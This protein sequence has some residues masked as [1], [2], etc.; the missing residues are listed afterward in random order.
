MKAS[1]WWQIGGIAL[2]SFFLAL[3]ILRAGPIG[4]QSEVAVGYAARTA[5]ACRY[6]GLRSLAS[7]YT[8]FEPGMGSVRLTEDPAEQRITAAVP[9]IA[10]RSAK[11]EPEYGCTLE[12]D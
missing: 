3:A 1:R 5:C 7:C 11:F 12:N 2:G 9:L 8:D 4:Q 6:L 10:A